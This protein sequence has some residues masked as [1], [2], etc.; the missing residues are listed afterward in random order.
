MKRFLLSWDKHCLLLLPFPS[1]S[2]MCDAWRWSNS[3]QSSQESLSQ[4]KWNPFSSSGWYK[5]NSIPF[6]NGWFSYQGVTQFCTLCEV[7]C[8]LLRKFFPALKRDSW[9]AILPPSFL[10]CFP[11]ALYKFYSLVGSSLSVF[12]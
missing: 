9:K 2:W 1:V 5:D 12:S 7:C 6:A 11:S 8:Q 10:G 3:F 4:G